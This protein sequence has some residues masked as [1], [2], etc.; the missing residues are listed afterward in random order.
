MSNFHHPAASARANLRLY[1]RRVVLRPLMANDFG[2]YHE[3]RVR[4]QDWLLAWEPSRMSL[5][6][7]P[8]HD[9]SA[10]AARCALRDRERQAGTAYGLGL[11]V[12]DQFI[13]EVNL[14]AVT[15]GA[16]QSATVGYWVDQAHA[17][18][19]YVAEAVVVLA[20]Y[21]FEELALHRLEI[22]IIP[23]NFRSRRVMEKLT[24]REEG[25]ALRYLEINGAW[26]DHVRYGFTVEEWLA[27]RDDLAHTWLGR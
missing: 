6:A 5:V 1:G 10:F 27:R 22:C 19:G 3:V 24:I 16:L 7:D 8:I 14:N 21:A 11:F 2:E 15:R 23:R 17:G 9:P 18:H 13:G 20:R 4:N 25:V 26:E 12:A